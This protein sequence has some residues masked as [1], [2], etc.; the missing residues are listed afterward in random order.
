M[1]KKI[2]NKINK[3]AAAGVSTSASAH[4][5]TTVKTMVKAGAGAEAAASAVAEPGK[6]QEEMIT[7]TNKPEQK[8]INSK[9]LWI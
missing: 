6:H 3:N 8:K 9:H 5:W 4:A 2:E 1:K 7:N